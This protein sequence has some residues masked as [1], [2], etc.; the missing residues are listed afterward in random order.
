MLKID[1]RINRDG[2]ITTPT[3]YWYIKEKWYQE[4]GFASLTCPKRDFW[5][6]YFCISDRHR[7]FNEYRKTVV[8]RTDIINHLDSEFYINKALSHV[9]MMCC[10]ISEYI[11]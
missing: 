5:D 2:S 6:F 9:R 10:K 1:I 3:S 11:N 7:F 8:Q 4:N